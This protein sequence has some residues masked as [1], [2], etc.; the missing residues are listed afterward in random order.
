[1]GVEVVASA[2]AVRDLSVSIPRAVAEV[3]AL[4]DIEELLGLPRRQAAVVLLGEAR[5]AAADAIADRFVATE[6]IS[7]AMTVTITM[8]ITGL[9]NSRTGQAERDGTGEQENIPHFPSFLS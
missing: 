5:R 6:P 2:Q 7:K 3:I 9:C 8:T 1:T 4:A